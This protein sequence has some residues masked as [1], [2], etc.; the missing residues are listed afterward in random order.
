[1]TGLV[2]LGFKRATAILAVYAL[3]G[4]V[5]AVVVIFILPAFVTELIRLAEALPVYTAG[6]RH[7]VRTIHDSYQRVAVPMGLR[8]TIDDIIMR[9]D[10][11]AQ[12]EIRAVGHALLGMARTLLGF[13]LAPWL[14]FYLLK[15]GGSL[16]AAVVGALPRGVRRD[17][18]SL[19]QRLDEVLSGFVRG[20]LLVAASVGVMAG[21]AT[22][23]LGL[24][25]AVVIGAL[26]GVAD[27]IP[28]FGPVIGALPAILLGLAVSPLRALQV[29]VAF[30]IV[31]QL[32]NAVVGPL[33]IGK[34]VQLHP[35]AVIFTVLAG[36][37]LSG[38][39]GMVLA[40]PAVAMARVLW[41]FGRDRVL[42]WRDALGREN[43]R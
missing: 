33:L 14:A 29:A 38:V 10:A 23:L 25:Y 17:V 27:A 30:V 7:W 18:L 22:W 26:A 36:G 5:L 39:W 15:D 19:V 21:V 28:Y 2:R 6:L 4:A 20:Q 1:M 12:A 37:A 13:F 24:R 32:E 41:G 40:V 42:D 8:A 11:S 9:L 31:Q 3:V 16:K 34:R 35:L 43:P